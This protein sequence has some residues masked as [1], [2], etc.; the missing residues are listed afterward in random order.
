MLLVDN[1]KSL[2]ARGPSLF[3]PKQ[4]TLHLQ[5]L[6]RSPFC[7]NSSWL[8]VFQ[9]WPQNSLILISFWLNILIRLLSI[10]KCLILWQSTFFKKTALL[11]L[12]HKLASSWKN[13]SLPTDEGI[14][15]REVEWGSQ[16]LSESEDQEASKQA[17]CK[18]VY[19]R[20]TFDLRFICFLRLSLLHLLGEI[21]GSKVVGVWCGD[22]KK[23][24]LR[25]ENWKLSKRLFSQLW[26]CRYSL[27]RSRI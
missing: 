13:I 10:Q 27:L 4:G 21:S 26:N 11:C 22:E 17:Y 23:R 25:Q 5:N 20:S 6:F 15:I 12:N 1:T 16:M 24:V 9:F 14:D 19:I 3:L 2:F 8:L 18:N 7:D